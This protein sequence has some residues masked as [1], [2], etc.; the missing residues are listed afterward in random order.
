MTKEMLKTLVNIVID[1]DTEDKDKILVELD[2]ELHRGDAVKATKAQV[3][4][5]AWEI[6]RE[7]LAMCDHATV[8]EI[9][10]SVGDCGL[11]KG[12]LVYALNHQWADRVTKGLG[13]DKVSTYALKV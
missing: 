12:Q 3:Y 9:S 5:T 6:V 11:T 1:S 13:K 10:D 4:E 2:K 7:S 8:A